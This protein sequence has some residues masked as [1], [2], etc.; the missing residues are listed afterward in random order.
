MPEQLRVDT[1]AVH[2]MA[3][4]WGALVTEL[5]ASAGPAR[6]GLADQPSAVAV[7]AAHAAT[8]AFTQALVAQVRS[9]AFQVVGANASY[10]ANEA[11]SAD[12][13]GGV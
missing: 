3:S 11:G 9:R 12:E 6:L 10:L 8:A 7:H 2:A 5:N 4:G 1:A 13:L